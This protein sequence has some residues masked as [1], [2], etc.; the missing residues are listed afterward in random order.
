[1]AILSILKEGD[2]VLREKSLPVKKITKKHQK[3]IKDMVQTMHEA[4]GVGLAAPQVGVLEQII[5]IDTGDGPFVLFNPE[6]VSHEGCERDVEGC[7]SVPGLNGYV[8]R[9]AKVVV[10]GLNH[11]GKPVRYEGTGLL[12]R[13]FQHEIDHLNGV[14]FID[15]LTVD[16]ENEGK[17]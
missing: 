16:H 17:A 2:P 8:T 3:L 5:V 9:A 10:N 11:E 13:A 15:Y 14:L 12:A 4:N 7:L 6:I 1:M